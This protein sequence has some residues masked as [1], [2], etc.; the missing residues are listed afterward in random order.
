MLWRSIDFNWTYTTF[1][2][3]IRM[4]VGLAGKAWPRRAE[5]HA[6]R[7]A[8]LFEKHKVAYGWD[9]KKLRFV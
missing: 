8:E 7:Y 4:I 3:S 6:A 5:L 9:T 2:M 1:M